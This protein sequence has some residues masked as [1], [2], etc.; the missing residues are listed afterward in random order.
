M[1]PSTAQAT[2]LVDELVRNGVEHVVVCP[3]SRNAPLLLALRD[4]ASAD[5]LTLHVRIDERSAGF[6]ALGIAARAGRATALVCTSG[7]AAANFH[8]AVLEADRAGVALLVCTADRPHELRAAGANQVVEQQRLYGDAVRYYA[9]L[10]VAGRTTGQN[11]YW[12]S[13]VCRAWHAAHG[14]WRS[15]PVHL[16][17][18]FRDPLLPDDD[19]QW[20]ESLRGRAG[21]APWTTVSEAG[22]APSVVVPDASRGL[23]IACDSAPHAVAEWAEQYGWPVLSETGGFGLSGRN[24]IRNGMWLLGDEGFI[25]E[26]KPEQVLCVGRPTVFRQVGRLL[27]D[28]DVEVLLVRPGIDWPA[29]GHNVRQVGQWF[30]APARQ[31]DPEWLAGWQRADS[32]AGSALHAALDRHEWPSG[33]GLAVEL[34]ESLPDGSLLT[35]GSSNPTRDVALAG[36]LRPDVVLHRNRGVAGIDGTVS[37][38]VGAAS[39][40]RGPAY[41]L[42]GDLT[43]LHDLNG[44]LSGSAEALPD[45]TIVVLNDDGG[46]IFSLLEQGDPRHADG[47]ERVFGTAHGADLGALCRGY[48]VPHTLAR[49]P[50]DLRAAL[51][52]T[53]GPH[54]IEVPV[55]R[56]THRALHARLAEA[57]SQAVLGPC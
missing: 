27:A 18:P 54:V 51:L 38:A 32:V 1:N 52:P 22:A 34:G 9:E 23:V 45:L 26:H 37:T 30:G 21:G 44:L 15:G 47:F 57:V 5:T 25:A 46:G 11:A 4:A 33:L 48:G 16:N 14:Q 12:R 19:S 39:V 42:L 35:T 2:V 6:L 43:F 13:Q 56:G 36:V 40:H 29:P 10:A 53:G 24:A 28:E 41:A 50:R 55:D 3:G 8:P 49:G 31:A 17:I 20:C 7:T